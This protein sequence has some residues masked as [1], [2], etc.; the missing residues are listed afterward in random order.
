MNDNEFVAG[1]IPVLS[2]LP[3]YH[4][5]ALDK[6]IIIGAVAGAI[7][8]AQP[9]YNYDFL[10]ST[11]EREDVE[12]I[13]SIADCIN[14]LKNSFQEWGKNSV[15]ESF[16]KDQLVQDLI[17]QVFSFQ[18][19]K[20]NWNGY[21]AIPVS[22]IASSFATMIIRHL[23]EA[24]LGHLFDIFPNANGTVSF[25]WSNSIGERISLNVGANGMSYYVAK[26]QHE[27]SFLDNIDVSSDSIAVLDKE[28]LSIISI[29]V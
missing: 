28:I 8:F 15:K 9:D 10:S 24:S 3:K 20:N 11:D 21:D 2:P 16:R 25:K 7:T 17:T 5:T 27:I 18:T 23:S 14:Q 26:L 4:P 29:D 6:L 1:D 19:L 12:Q 13:Y 22:A